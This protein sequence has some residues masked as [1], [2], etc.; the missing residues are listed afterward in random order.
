MQME[1]T[2]ATRLL[3]RGSWILAYIWHSNWHNVSS[4]SGKV[5]KLHFLKSQQKS[6]KICQD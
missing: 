6:L 1:S 4:I 5:A 3:F 2:K